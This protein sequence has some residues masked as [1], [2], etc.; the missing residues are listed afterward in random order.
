[1]KMYKVECYTGTSFGLNASPSGIFLVC[2]TTPITPSCKSRESIE[3]VTPTCVTCTRA[4]SL[5]SEL[6]R[7]ILHNVI[8]YSSIKLYN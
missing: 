3:I 2:L 1:M 5:T 8:D 6:V 4:I 7:L